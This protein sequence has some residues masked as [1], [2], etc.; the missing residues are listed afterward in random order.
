M[1]SNG[2]ETYLYYRCCRSHLD[3]RFN[4]AFGAVCDMRRNQLP[5]WAAYVELT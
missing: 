3:Y 2:Y 4:R 5:D 1:F